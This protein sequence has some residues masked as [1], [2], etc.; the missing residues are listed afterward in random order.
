M[1]S[2]ANYALIYTCLK[3][4]NKEPFIFIQLEEWQHSIHDDNIVVKIDIYHMAQMTSLASDLGVWS[5]LFVTGFTKMC[6][7]LLKQDM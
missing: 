1:Y 7:N 4:L 5:L 3:H 2:G 6:Q